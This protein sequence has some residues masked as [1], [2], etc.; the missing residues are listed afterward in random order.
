MYLAI[1]LALSVL[2][3]TCTLA[4][5]AKVLTPPAEPVPVCREMPRDLRLV[6]TSHRE[7]IAAMRF[8]DWDAALGESRH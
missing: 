3:F 6:D 4:L 7:A 5:I 1:C 2:G 8:Y